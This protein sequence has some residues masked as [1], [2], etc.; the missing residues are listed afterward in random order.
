MSEPVKPEV[1]KPLRDRIDEIDAEVLRLLNERART[2]HEIGTLKN[3]GVI[4]RPEREAQV[5]RRLQSLNTGPLSDET[6]RHLYT[7]VISACRAIEEPLSV[8][9]LGPRGTFS[10]EAAR[11]HF[12]ASANGVPCAS[13]DEVFRQVEAGQVRFG[14]V[15]VENSTEGAIGRTLDLLVTSTVKLCGEVVLPVHQ[16]LMSKATERAGVVRIL[17]HAQSLAQCHEWI[18]LN[19]PRVDRV[20][21]VSNAEA[22]RLA[23]QDATAASL[24]SRSAAPLFG[25]NVL[26]ENIEDQPN[27]TTRFVVLADRDP[28]PSGRDKTSLIMSGQNRPGTMHALLTP[29]AQHGVSMSRLESRPSRMGLWEYLFFVDIEGHRQ[30]PKVAQAL[31][32]VQ[33]QAAFI[34]ILGS[35]PVAV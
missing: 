18:N 12:G 19:F 28:A 20:P 5:L 2:A 4:Y 29:F 30:D 14:V 31:A 9:F 15:P 23:G 11:K 8:G 21:V 1:L 6:V 34:K 32:D 24:G 3:D 35:Y 22:A 10:E 25:L 16:C 7:E 33:A 26:A 17:G 13:I 27:N